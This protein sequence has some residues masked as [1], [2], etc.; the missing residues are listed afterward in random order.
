[1]NSFS[2]P[3]TRGNGRHFTARHAAVSAL[4]IAVLASP[5]GALAGDA[6]KTVAPVATSSIWEKPAWLTDL[7]LRVGESYDSNVYLE[8]YQATPADLA[9][10][11]KDLVTPRNKSSW[12][13][14]ITPKI[15][16]DFAKFFEKDAFVKTLAIGY[17]PDIV[18]FHD[19]SDESYQAHRITTV[20]KGQTDRVTVT[21]DNAATIIN[22]SDEGLIYP[23]ASAYANG[24]IRE[25]RSQWQDR[26]KGAVKVDLGDF[27]L[28][29][30][31]ALTYYNL[32]TDFYNTNI[33]TTNYYKGYTNFID[34]YDLNGG[35]DVGYKVSKDVAFTLGYRYG[36]QYQQAYP[37]YATGTAAS[38]TS[39]GRDSS[40]NYQRVLVGVE[41]SPLKW[42]KIEAQAGPQFTTYTDDRPYRD[43]VKSYGLVDENAT[44]V[45]G[46]ASVTIA[47]TKS[48][49]LVLKYKHWRWVASTGVNAYEDTTYD[50]SFRHQITSD[51]QLALGL[52]AS[53]SDYNPY[54]LRND[55]L[56]T[57]SVGLKYNITKNLIWDISYAYDRA[58]NG[59]LQT[60]SAAGVWSNID[61]STRQFDRSVVSSGITWAF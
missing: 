55:W 25:R 43:T 52:R 46:E 9:P 14:T 23:A 44:S 61:S 1:M 33:P 34:R 21:L 16:V 36:H 3:T 17:S 37:V 48:D 7:S 20:F 6:S 24:T 45:Y 42:L 29:P 40:N 32:D 51:L 38:S 50:A 47:P 31:V 39:Y 11:R 49:A 4:A 19:A 56:Y 53:N 28:R 58:E 12:V 30:T 2:K 54:Q 35:A 59:Q 13:T 10:L 18:V 27:F 57:A 5:L 15:G 8:G 26:L 41:G 22:G 60:A